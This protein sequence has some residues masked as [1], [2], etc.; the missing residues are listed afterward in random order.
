MV[1]IQDKDLK[2]STLWQFKWQI[3]EQFLKKLDEEVYI[4]VNV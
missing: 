2:F 4:K 1:H 3:I